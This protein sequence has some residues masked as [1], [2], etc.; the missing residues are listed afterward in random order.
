MRDILEQDKVW[1]TRDNRAVKLTDMS[2]RHRRN[3]LEY[4]CR[5][6]SA[7]HTKYILRALLGPQPTPGSMAEDAFEQAIDEIERTPPNVW[8]ETKPLVARLRL[9]VEHD[10][11]VELKR[12]ASRP[13]WPAVG[14]RVGA[15]GGLR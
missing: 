7:Y 12:R 15:T 3:V 1:V 2:P 14:V 6:A 5:H 11:R 13:A 8:L 10:R 4:L 9:L